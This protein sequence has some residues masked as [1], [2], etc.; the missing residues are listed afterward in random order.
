MISTIQPASQASYKCYSNKPYRADIKGAVYAGTTPYLEFTKFFPSIPDS[1]PPQSQAEIVSKLQRCLQP[2]NLL[3]VNMNSIKA[4]AFFAQ[5]VI[6]ARHALT[7]GSHVTIDPQG[8]AEDCLHVEYQLIKYPRALRADVAESDEAFAALEAGHEIESA[9]LTKRTPNL[10]D[11]LA[12]VAAILYIEDLLPDVRSVDLYSILLT[13][14]THQL[15]NTI[16]AIRHRG[17]DPQLNPTT[18]T[19]DIIAD[20]L[21]S[22][23]SARPVLLWA[24]LIGHAIANFVLQARPASIIDRSAFEDCVALLLVESSGLKSGDLELCEVLP[25]REL[26]AVSCDESTLLRQIV[27]GYEAKQVWNPT[28]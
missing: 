19:P 10:L 12:R 27:A 1:L 11:A 21:P 14:L 2:A 23:E 18:S 8:Y 24:C 13:V 28:G 25:I 4:L 16:L 22:I 17:I 9:S 20:S 7:A 3:P 26:R 6:L 5:T 15:R